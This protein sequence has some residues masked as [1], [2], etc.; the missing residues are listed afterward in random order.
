MAILL[1]RSFFS[2]FFVSLPRVSKLNCAAFAF[3]V[4]RM[5]TCESKLRNPRNAEETVPDRIS[6]K[7]SRNQIQGVAKKKTD[8]S[9]SPD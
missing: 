4:P 7:S 6:T 9:Y 2:V 8:L 3:V 1:P 5:L